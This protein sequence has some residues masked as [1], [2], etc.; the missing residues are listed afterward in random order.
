[1]AIESKRNTI[2]YFEVS[3]GAGMTTGGVHDDPT[4]LANCIDR[5]I[6]HGMVCDS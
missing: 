1:M 4:G 6:K 2:I 5:T 3:N